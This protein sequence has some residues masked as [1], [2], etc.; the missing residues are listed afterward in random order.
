MPNNISG[1][2]CLMNVL[3]NHKYIGS[4]K[5]IRHRI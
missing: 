4:S 3:N 1:I 5:N 2:Y